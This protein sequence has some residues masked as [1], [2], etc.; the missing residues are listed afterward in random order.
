MVDLCLTFKKLPNSSN[1]VVSFYS[2]TNS[3]WIQVPPILSKDCSLLVYRNSLKF[4]TL[5]LYFTALLNLLISFGTFFVDSLTFYMSSANKDI[6]TY[7]LLIWMSFIYFSCL[8]ALFRTSS[9][10]LN[11][12]NTSNLLLILGG[13]QLVFHY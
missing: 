4:C 10:V 5:I 1:V 11:T 13:K 9:S 12:G 2:L 3:A 6:F 7:S 8:I